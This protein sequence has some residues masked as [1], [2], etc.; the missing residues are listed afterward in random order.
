MA[1]LFTSI[2]LDNDGLAG[3]HEIN[4]DFMLGLL[5]TRFNHKAAVHPLEGAYICLPRPPFDEDAAQ[6][7]AIKQL[8]AVWDAVVADWQQNGSKAKSLHMV[9]DPSA[10]APPPPKAPEKKT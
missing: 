10:P 6:D 9:P 1:S 7:A 8:I 3:Y 5:Q 4:S 2:D